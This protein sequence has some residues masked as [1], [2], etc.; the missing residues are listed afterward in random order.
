MVHTRATNTPLL[1]FDPEIERAHLRRL[2][3]ALER[4]VTESMAE[5]TL[6]QLNEPELSQQHLG[7]KLPDLDV[8]VNFEL[9]T[10]FIQLLPKFHGLAGEGPIMNLSEF[11]DVCQCIKPNN[12]TDEQVKMRAFGFTLK[13]SARN[14]YYLLPTGSI[15]TWP[16]LHKA[17]LDKYFPSK[18]V[19]ALKRAIANV[20]QADD[21][22][23]YE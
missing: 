19:V 14:W 22:S 2:R 20:E 11:H 12:V 4:L 17:F 3:Q 21:E 23:L 7:V 6:R 16:K 5:G 1:D 13:D 9:K 8:G 18:K 10:S 15:D